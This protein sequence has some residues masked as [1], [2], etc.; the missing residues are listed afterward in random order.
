MLGSVS[1]VAF[2]FVIC[3]VL[4]SRRT[5]FSDFAACNLVF[6][7]ATFYAVALLDISGERTEV[8]LAIMTELPVVLIVAWM[9]V[10]LAGGLPS[11]LGALPVEPVARR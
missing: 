5:K 7:A 8:F 10:A 2:F 6:V 4:S 3:F 1:F 11:H 9:C